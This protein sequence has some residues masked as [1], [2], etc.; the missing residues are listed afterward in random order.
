GLHDGHAVALGGQPPGEY[1][2][3]GPGSHRDHIQRRAAQSPSPLL[4]AC[5]SATV[6]AG[7]RPAP[8]AAGAG[9]WGG[10]APRARPPPRHRGPA[11][12]GNS[13]LPRGELGVR[14]GGGE[15]G[16]GGLVDDPDPRTVDVDPDRAVRGGLAGSRVDPGQ[17]V[18]PGGGQ[19]EHDVLVDLA[20]VEPF[21]DRLRRPQA[22]LGVPERAV[23]LGVAGVFWGGGDPQGA[24]RVPPRGRSRLIGGV[25]PARASSAACP[26]LIGCTT[27][28]ACGLPAPVWPLMTPNSRSRAEPRKSSPPL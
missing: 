17:Q 10:A 21:P 5:A 7:R 9:G 14:G 16:G 1:F 3:G 28:W 20:R 11:R 12:S 27:P 8:S 6:P 25:W 19:V 13:G 24:G 22:E 18:G 15:G 23:G 4:L 2:T 26:S